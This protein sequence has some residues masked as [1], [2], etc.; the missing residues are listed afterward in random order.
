MYEKTW[1]ALNDANI[2]LYPVDVRG[3]VV[4]GPSAATHVTASG[5][6][7]ANRRAAWAHQD[8]LTTFEQFADM[9][10]GK[11]YFNTNDLVHAFH[12]SVDDSASYYMLGFYLALQRPQARL[13]Q[14]A[15]QGQASAR[16]GTRP[17]RLLRHA[18]GQGQIQVQANRHRPGPEFAARFHCRT[19]LAR[20]TETTRNGDKKRTAFELIPSRQCRPGGRIRPEP[21]EHR[22]RCRR[23]RTR[24]KIVAS[25]GRTLDAH[26]KP[27]SLQQIRSD[28]ITYK[29][30]LDLPPGQYTVRFVV[31]DNLSG[32]MGSVAAPLTVPDQ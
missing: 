30:A 24:G 17:Q 6:Q 4:R 23:P 9:T 27:E 5:L 8:T 29:G 21:H 12:D 15:S 25:N 31:R 28:G 18:R 11:A 32:R 13:A 10:G 20:W 1:Q 7:T 19:V 3:L 16:P 2:A 26:L 14:A 22:F